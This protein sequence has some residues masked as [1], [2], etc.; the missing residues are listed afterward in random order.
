MEAILILSAAVACLS[1]TVSKSQ[2]FAPL[3]GWGPPLWKDLLACPWCLN[4]WFA[5][6]F[7]D[8]FW[9]PD[10]WVW[11]FCQYLA[12]VAFATI[13]AGLMLRLLLVYQSENAELKR[14][15][16]AFIPKD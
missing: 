4:H 16:A 14:K 2:V 3:R 1:T 8:A 11:N 13:I 9:I 12:I 7:F 6:L 10:A 15:L 5:L